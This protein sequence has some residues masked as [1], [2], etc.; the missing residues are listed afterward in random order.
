MTAANAHDTAE[1]WALAETYL[2]TK[3][4]KRGRVSPHNVRSY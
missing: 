1:L 4:R 2:L 3:E